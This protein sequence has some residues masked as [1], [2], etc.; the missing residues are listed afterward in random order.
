MDHIYLDEPELT[1]LEDGRE[2]Y[3]TETWVEPSIKRRGRRI[4][5][6]SHDEFRGAFLGRSEDG[7]W[8]LLPWSH[9]QNEDPLPREISPE[10]AAGWFAACD[11]DLPEELEGYLL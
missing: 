5:A 3:L 2:V 9:H 4:S 8:I 11:I 6:Y 1:I 7:S 10:E